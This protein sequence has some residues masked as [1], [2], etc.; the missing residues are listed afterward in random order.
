MSGLPRRPGVRRCRAAERG[1][2]LIEFVLV[3]PLLLFMG[4]GVVQA[5][6]IMHAKSQVNYA[7]FEAARAGTTQHARLEAIE[8]AFRRGMVGYYGGGRTPAEL[9][10]A[11][12][13]A[14]RDLAGGALR[15]EILSPTR[16]SFDDYE[17]PE[18]SAKLGGGHRVIPNLHLDHLRCPRDRAGCANDPATNRSGQTLADANLLKLRV[19]YGIPP[20]K[21]VPLVGPFMNWALDAFLL[22]ADAD[23]FRKALL[24]R[25]RLPVVAHTTM[26]MQSE[27][28]ENAAMGS[29]PGA[30]KPRPVDPGPPPVAGDP[31]PDCPYYEPRC[32]SPRP[33]ACDPTRSDCDP[34]GPGAPGGDP[35]DPC[36]G[37]VCPPCGGA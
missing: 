2:S 4:L 27:A 35:S 32:T 12:A 29:A 8:A 34:G 14:T 28:I 19:T 13:R 15:I 22:R 5:A 10:A 21:Q 18:L 20:A 33:P 26:R 16:E 11:F 30:G 1:A 36:P 37:G 17:S 7:L 3:A 6:L 31:L 24:G 23:T 9:S 25:G